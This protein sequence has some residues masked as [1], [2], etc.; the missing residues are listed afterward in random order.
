MISKKNFYLSISATPYC[1]GSLIKNSTNRS[2]SCDYKLQL[3]TQPKNL[4]FVY[5]IYI[6][7]VNAFIDST[8]ICFFYVSLTDSIFINSF[9]RAVCTKL[10]SYS[11]SQAH[12]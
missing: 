1:I 12:F 11:F 2:F 3:Y 5:R 4:N 8:S 6:A 9:K 7:S 10:K